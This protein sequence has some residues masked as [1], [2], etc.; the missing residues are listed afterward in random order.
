M[1]RALNAITN[2]INRTLGVGNAIV[3]A[4]NG[5]LEVAIHPREVQAPA[6]E[7]AATAAPPASAPITETS[8]SDAS[9]ARLQH[10]L[11]SDQTWIAAASTVS[12]RSDDHPD[13]LQSPALALKLGER[14]QT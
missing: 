1:E 14:T 10:V 8:S 5:K 6:P 12:G 13:P 11:T 7:L 3:T 4:S 9:R 2:D